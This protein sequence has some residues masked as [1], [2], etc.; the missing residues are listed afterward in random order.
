LKKLLDALTGMRRIRS[1]DPLKTLKCVSEW[2]TLFN[3]ISSKSVWTL[4]GVELIETA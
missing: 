3:N 4:T 2:S 1:P